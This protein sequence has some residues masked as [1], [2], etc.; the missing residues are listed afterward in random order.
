MRDV[1]YSKALSLSTMSPQKELTN[2][3]DVSL[4]L[5]GVALGTQ[6]TS[7]LPHCRLWESE[8]TAVESE[9]QMQVST[10]TLNYLTGGH[11]ASTPPCSHQLQV[12]VEHRGRGFATQ[13]LFLSFK[14]PQWLVAD[15]VN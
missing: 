11:P 7:G 9:V 12:A 5:K 14:D 10:A 4:L 1:C 2:V 13:F 6:S 3:S 8:V 15:W